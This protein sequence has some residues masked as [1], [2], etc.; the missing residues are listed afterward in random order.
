[1]YY[2]FDYFLMNKIFIQSNNRTSFYK[3]VEKCR[4]QVAETQKNI[5]LIRPNLT[6]HITNGIRKLPNT[7]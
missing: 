5:I 4:Q 2:L 3:Q 1:M 7:K 6:K